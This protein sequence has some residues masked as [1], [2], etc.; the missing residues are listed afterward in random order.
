MDRVTEIYN[1]IKERLTSPFIFSY[2]VAFFTYNWKVTVAL[3]FYNQQEI[4]AAGYS[5]L[6][7]FIQDNANH[8]DTLLCPLLFAALYTLIY[9]FLKLGINAFQTWIGVLDER[10]SLNI[11]KGHKI[12]VAKYLEL[13]AEVN[14]Q[15]ERLQQVLNDDSANKTEI[16]ELNNKL[17]ESES[18]MERTKTALQRVEHDLND[19]KRQLASVTDPAP[20]A[21]EWKVFDSPKPKFDTHS[22]RVF[23]DKKEIHLI[24]PNDTMTKIFDIKDFFYDVAH[25]HNL[26]FTIV[27]PKNLSDNE[28]VTTIITLTFHSVKLERRGEDFAG[29]VDN[30]QL[31]TFQKVP[32]YTNEV[33]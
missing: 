8:T 23:I 27:K 3:L 15:S 7:K 33:N 16:A 30:K 2:I 9:P 19:H 10:L 28:S 25:K 24:Q 14:V 22:M 21:G 31:I 17:A 4:E 11:S 18:E 5:S 29:I 6:F 12:P 32:K 1:A 13:K 20:L 26:L